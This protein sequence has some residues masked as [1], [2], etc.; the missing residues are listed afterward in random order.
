VVDTILAVPSAVIAK[1]GKDKWLAELKYVSKLWKMRFVA[2]ALK[3]AR[4]V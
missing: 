1:P 3:F 4:L 2:E